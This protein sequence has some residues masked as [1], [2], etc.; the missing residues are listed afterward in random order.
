MMAMLAPA[1]GHGRRSS[2]KQPFQEQQRQVA[3]KGAPG[4]YVAM[5]GGAGAG[6]HI[7]SSNN[8]SRLQQSMWLRQEEQQQPVAMA[9]TLAGDDVVVLAA[10]YGEQQQ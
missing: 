3:M 7:K 5:A 6:S 8:S 4:T 1:D 10:V 2:S 9:R